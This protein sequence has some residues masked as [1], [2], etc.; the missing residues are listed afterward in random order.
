MMATL[1]L[2]QGVP[3]ILA[4]DELGN[5]QAGNNNAYCQDNPTGWVDWDGADPEF[6]DFCRKIIAFRRHSPILRQKWFLHSQPRHVD[7]IPDLFWR[8]ADG[9]AM[10]DAD[11]AAP[12]LMFLGME[13][14]MAR[15]TPPYEPRL[16][17]IYI[18]FNAGASVDATLPDAPE[19]QFW[20]R[21]FDTAESGALAPASMDTKIAAETVAVFD[22]IQ[23]PGASTRTRAMTKKGQTA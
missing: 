12:G 16:G 10:S 6:L 11:W 21:C 14:R 5:S 8:R 13:V 9:T 3:M 15:G 17:A 1:M 7:G 4:G 22:L 18:V 19:G 2:S 20:R 23:S